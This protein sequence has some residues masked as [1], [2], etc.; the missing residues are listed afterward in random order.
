MIKETIVALATAL[1]GRMAHLS[2]S[3]R[4]GE[5]PIPGSQFDSAHAY[6]IGEPSQ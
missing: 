6:F 1:V 2:E 5:F 4:K 3:R